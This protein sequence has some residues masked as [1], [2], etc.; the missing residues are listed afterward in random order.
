MSRPSPPP[1][2]PFS[3][4]VVEWED[5][6]QPRPAWEWVDDYVPDAAIACV[7]VGYLVIDRDDV[8]CL[9]PNLGDI[10]HK[11]CQASGIMRI[12]RSAVRRIH[13]ITGC[14]P[15]DPSRDGCPNS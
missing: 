10:E 7:S 8:I 6:A 9:A 15:Y 14:R 13:V 12:P 3:L 2:A 4:V 1:N 5:S 11:R